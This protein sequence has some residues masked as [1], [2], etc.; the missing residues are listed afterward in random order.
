MTTTTLT[1]TRPWVDHKR[2]LWLLSP[3]IPV[4]ALGTF[5]LYQSTAEAVYAW[6]GW[7]LLYGIIPALDWIVG[8]DHVNA[9]ESAV[10]GLDADRYYR[11]IVYAFIPTQFA[12]TV[13]GA[14]LL[15]TM[16]PDWWVALGLALTVGS[17]NGIA[18]NTAHELGHKTNKLER[19]LAKI[20]LAPVAYGH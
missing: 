9:P 7:I 16:H 13:W 6:G 2:Y 14:W 20:T 17:V 15:A 4:L 19:W 12:V 5:A 1:A 11:W 18:I 8:P 10:S 3:A